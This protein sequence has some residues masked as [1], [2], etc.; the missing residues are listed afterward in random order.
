NKNVEIETVEH[1]VGGEPMKVP[2]CSYVDRD[3]AYRI[4]NEFITTKSMPTF[5]EWVDLYE[6]DFDQ[7]F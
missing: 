1:L 6:I 4:I 3:L 5:I 7:G 2:S